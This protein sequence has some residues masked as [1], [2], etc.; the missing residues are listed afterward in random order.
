MQLFK[1]IY[2][3]HSNIPSVLKHMS[4]STNIVNS[5]QRKMRRVSRLL[6]YNICLA[7]ATWT[8]FWTD[9]LAFLPGLCLPFFVTV[10][11]VRKA[12]VMVDYPILCTVGF[13]SCFLK[14][15]F[16]GNK[17]KNICNWRNFFQQKA[18]NN[19]PNMISS[20]TISSILSCLT[21]SISIWQETAKAEK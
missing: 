8:H 3:R 12:S 4:R 11:R 6:D 15:W 13:F 17:F 21:I 2:Q 5:F 16:L 1:T 14:E 20:D 7:C 9:C 19:A 10:R 18:K